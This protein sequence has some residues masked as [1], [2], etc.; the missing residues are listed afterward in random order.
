MNIASLRFPRRRSSAADR[1]GHRFS[2]ATVLARISLALF[3]AL[4]AGA[5][6]GEIYKCT[7]KRRITTYQNFPC[8]FDSLGSV[9]AA[10]EPVVGAAAGAHTRPANR[11]ATASVPRA[12]MTTD[13]V[14]AIWGEPNGTS[15][16]EFVKGDIE[17]WTYDDSRSV[18]FDRKGRV[19]NIKW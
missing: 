3:V 5:A 4:S 16:E 9:P 2:N 12:G 8:E 6:S 15:K 19:T 14:K 17:T 10:F 13:D 7:A 18:Q 11:A 1:S